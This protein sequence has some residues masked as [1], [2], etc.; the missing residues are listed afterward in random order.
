ME[1]AERQGRLELQEAASGAGAAL[2][3]EHLRRVA[4]GHRREAEGQA[5]QQEAQA[6]LSAK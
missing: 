5:A 6:K 1:A 3:H 4:E 2:M